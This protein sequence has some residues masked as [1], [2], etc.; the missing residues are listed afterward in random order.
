MWYFIGWS[1][2]YLYF[3]LYLNVK[4]VGRRNIPAKG[5]FIFASNHASYI[6]PILLGTSI[7]RSLNYMAHEGLFERRFLAWALPKV[8]AFPVKRGQGDLGAMRQALKLLKTGKPLVIFPEGTRTEDRQLQ[9]GKPGIGLI[10][11][12]SGVSVVPAYIEGSFDAMPRGMKRLKRRQVRVYIGKPM[13]FDSG[14]L[15]GRDA[16]QNISDRI[17]AEIASLKKSCE[18]GPIRITAVARQGSPA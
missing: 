11:A 4:V 5:S 17:M 13:R 8:Q 2:F 14:D 9:R 18:S 6:D 10:V 16:Y 3:K 12:R 1:I 15:S 7:H